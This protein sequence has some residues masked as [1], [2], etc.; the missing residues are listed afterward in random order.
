MVIADERPQHP[1]L[2]VDQLGKIRVTVIGFGQKVTT[3]DGFR[4]SLEDWGVD[5]AIVDHDK[6][7]VIGNELGK[8]RHRKQN[9]KNPQRP[10]A[11]A[12]GTKVIQPAPGQRAE[13]LCLHLSLPAIEI[14][15][16]INHGVHEVPDQ[17][18]QQAQQR[19]EEQRAEHHRIIAGERGL[20]T[21]QAQTVQ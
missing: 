3:K 2:G 8:K 15:P 4:I 14:N 11:A 9:Q 20:K 7:L 21:Q 10:P 5:L 16:R 18:H 17:A 12:V 1:A 6:G 19:E 13:T